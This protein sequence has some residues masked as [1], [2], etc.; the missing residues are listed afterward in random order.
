MAAEPNA[1]IEPIAPWDRKFMDR[2]YDYIN[3]PL[4]T[5]DPI[6]NLVSGVADFIPGISTAL[7]R[8][9]GDTM[10]EAL[11]YLDYLGGA[12]L[13][14]SP[15]LIARKKE[16]QQTLK[17]F[18]DDPLLRGNESV[19]TALKKE[20]DQINKQEAKELRLD[21]QFK[22]I[23]KD[24]TK[25][26]KKQPKK[27]IADATKKTGR[28]Q[29]Q[30][31]LF[32]GSK[33]KGIKNLKLPEDI[34]KLRIGQRHSSSGGLYSLVDPT[35]P[36]FKSFSKG[37]S[38][39][40]LQPNFKNILDVDNIPDNML[41]VLQDTEM[42]RGRPSRDSVGGI[43]DLM[44]KKRTD[45]QLDTILRGGRGS[46][47]KTPANFTSQTADI[48]TKEGYD[49]LKFPPRKMK[50]EQSTMLSLDPSNLEIV[51]EIPFDQLDDYIR[52]LLE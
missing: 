27:E 33:T 47:Y 21:K 2:I 7:A 25:F 31:L 40:V 19:R 44:K 9:R 16:I 4:N 26:G 23:Q 28:K 42:Y 11:S 32:H 17:T 52:K 41:K 13:A 43:G 24:P 15:L 36:R 3:Q 45:F 34:A 48:F 18:D 20:L 39:Y 29:D 1:T 22:D 35:D 49:A 37:G 30:D 12:K 46:T 50:G 5:E 8:Q 14:L 10:G 51:D 38:G 6:Q